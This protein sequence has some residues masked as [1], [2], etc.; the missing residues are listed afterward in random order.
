METAN[1]KIF[2]SFEM[3]KTCKKCNVEKN[4]NLFFKDKTKKDGLR[5]HCAQK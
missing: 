5:N 1:K 4:L 3:T 2:S